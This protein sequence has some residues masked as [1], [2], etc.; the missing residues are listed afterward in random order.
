M[1]CPERSHLLSLIE[2]GQDNR[3]RIVAV[4]RGYFDDSGTHDPTGQHSGADVSGAAGYVATVPQWAKFD[5]AWRPIL[6]H[7]GVP[8][9]KFHAFDLQWKRG[10]YKDW[11]L[12]KEKDFVEQLTAVTNKHL[13]FGVGGFALAKD[14]AQMPQEFRDEVKDPFVVGVNAV[15]RSFEKGPFV[16]LLKKRRVNLFFER[17]SPFLEE[18]V[19]KMF[20]HLR[21]TRMGHILG[22][23]TMGGDKSNLLPLHAADLAAYHLRAELSRLEYKPHLTMRHTMNVLLKQ[24]RLGLTYYDL[25]GLRDAYFKLKIERARLA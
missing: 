13:L 1:L 3:I 5:M 11:C 15:F 21:D 25:D 23:I 10:W 18:E 22:E 6:K 24:Y 7:F 17:M 19:I 9:E 12:E 4:L 20:S 14:L 16:P 2:I 8:P